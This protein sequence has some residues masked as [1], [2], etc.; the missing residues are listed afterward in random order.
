MCEYSQ[1]S[2]ASHAG[3]VPGSLGYQKMGVLMSLIENNITSAYTLYAFS[4]VL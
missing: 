2:L 4:Q 3:L 1:P